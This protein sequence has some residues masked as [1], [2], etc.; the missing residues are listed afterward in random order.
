MSKSVTE[1]PQI[2]V[3][4]D[5]KVIRHMAKKMLSSDYQVHLAEDGRVAWETL[6]KESAIS[7]VFTDLNMPNLNGM[8]LL[9]RI[10]DTSTEHIARVPVI[11]MTGNED[12][13]SEKQ[14]VFDAGATDFITKPFKSIHLLSRAKTYIRLSRKTARLEKK[15]AY[16]KLTGLYNASTLQKQA[17]KAV[18][19]AS[20]HKL[21][22]SVVLFEIAESQKYSLNSNKGVVHHIIKTVG[23][24][25]QQGLREED[26]AAR[27]GVT[28]YA[29]MLPMTGKQEVKIVINRICQRVNKLVFDTGKE[30]IRINLAVGYASPDIVD[31]KIFSD[32]LKQADHAL[33]QAIHST[34]EQVVCYDQQTGITTPPEAITENNIE[35][36]FS[37]ILAGKFYQIPEQHLTTVLD[38]LS[39]FL[40]YAARRTKN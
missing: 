31:A 18:S 40:K 26:V 8:G 29:L 16:D 11:I 12:S 20:R 36:A 10:R 28:K 6:Q 35:Q 1:K 37:S 3:V 17:A 30:K 33:Q 24:R 5:S 2:L 34:T 38:R 39:P 25:L 15:T 23:A 7:I 32:I 19:F 22:V 21:P 9:K 4:D 13:E 14:Q 27:I